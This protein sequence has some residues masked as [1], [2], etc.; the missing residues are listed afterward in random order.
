LIVP[1]ISKLTTNPFSLLV[2]TQEVVDPNNVILYIRTWYLVNNMYATIVEP[3]LTRPRVMPPWQIIV[4][5]Y[6]VGHLS[7]APIIT[8]IILAIPTNFLLGY[9]GVL[10]DFSSCMSNIWNHKLWPSAK[11]QRVTY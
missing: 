1:N 5:F 6:M 4:H 11:V 2:P 8:H 10:L 3:T 7:F 9:S